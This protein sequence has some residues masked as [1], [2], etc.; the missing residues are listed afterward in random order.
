MVR[1]G[2]LAAAMADAVGL[3]LAAASLAQG[4]PHD[5]RVESLERGGLVRD[6]DSS[7]R[8]HAR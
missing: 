6:D 5:E 3:V 4:E 8:D 1:T 7:N 2:L